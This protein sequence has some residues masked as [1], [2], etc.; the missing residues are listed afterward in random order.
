MERARVGGGVVQA[1]EAALGAGC[2]MIV[3]CNAPQAA[4]EVL[5]GLKAG[6]LDRA[7]AERMRGRGTSKPLGSDTRYASA[8]STVPGVSGLNSRVSTDHQ[9]GPP[10]TRPAR[11]AFPL[12]VAP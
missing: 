6:P 4:A 8:G 7:R 9:H 2:D 1:V 3:V 11:P 5:D 12:G 10:D